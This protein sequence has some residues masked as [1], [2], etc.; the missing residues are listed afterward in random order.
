MVVFR[1][2]KEKDNSCILDQQKDE[3]LTLYAEYSRFADSYYSKRDYVSAKNLYEKALLYKANDSKVQNQI[4]LCN[5]IL[6]FESYKS[7]AEKFLTEKKFN[8]AKEIFLKISSEYSEHKAYAQSKVKECDE[9]IRIENYN[10]YK[11]LANENYKKSF[12]AKAIENFR[13]ALNYDKSETAYINEMI[14]KCS[15]SDQ[16]FAQT[17]IKKAVYLAEKKNDYVG[18]FKIL[19]Y[20]EASNLLS[21]QNYYFMAMMLDGN[22]DRIRQKVNYSKKQAYHLAK[23]YCLKG[24]SLGNKNA[25]FMWNRILNGKS[26][27]D[28]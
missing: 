15:I 28:Y 24:M 27:T 3:Q 4:K 18:A 21:G 19:S 7:S 22:Q 17:Q 16:N 2:Y 9:G 20:Y 23:E 11:N 1:P 5:N 6:N 26:K 12:Y 8:Q 14:H 25:E 13:N 10:F